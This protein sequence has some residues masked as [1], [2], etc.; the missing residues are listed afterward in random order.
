MRDEKGDMLKGA[1]MIGFFRRICKLLYLKIRPVFVFDGPPPTLKWQTLRLRAQQRASEERIRRKAVERLLRNQLQ[2]HILRAAGA[3]SGAA[4]GASN[5]EGEREADGRRADEPAV[6][7]E[8]E[9]DLQQDAEDEGSQSEESVASAHPPPEVPAA[10]SRRWERR[11]T[12]NGTV[13]LP[14]RGFM[15]KRR[16]VSEVVVPELPDEP[17]RDILQVPDRRN[18]RGRMRQPD[19]W[20]AV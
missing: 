2:Q 14:F 13:P 4:A 19:E 7:P 10:G 12:R 9:Q 1:H 15:A 8:R 3:A 11:R 18:A 6:A 5:V 17:L 20:K 16:G